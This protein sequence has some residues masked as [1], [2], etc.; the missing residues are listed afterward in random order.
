[1]EYSLTALGRSL[2]LVICQLAE[3]GE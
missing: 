3:W 2:E 1:M